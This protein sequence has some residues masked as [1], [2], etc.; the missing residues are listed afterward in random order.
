MRNRASAYKLGRGSVCG[1][2]GGDLQNCKIVGNRK[3]GHLNITV[4]LKRRVDYLTLKVVV[5]GEQFGSQGFPLKVFPL[6]YF[7]RPSLIVAQDG[8]RL[9]HC[10][11]GI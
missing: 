6:Q 8:S 1:C 7:P 11:A 9:P 3:R 4:S 5:Y 10:Q 2:Q